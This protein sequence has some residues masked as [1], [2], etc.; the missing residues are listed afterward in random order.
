[1]APA[2]AEDIRGLFGPRARVLPAERVGELVPRG[3]E[4]WTTLVALLVLAYALEAAAG[5]IASVRNERRRRQAGG[6]DD[7]AGNGAGSDIDNDASSSNAGRLR[8]AG[9]AKTDNPDRPAAAGRRSERQEG[10]A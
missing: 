9:P 6:G 4:F 8:P 10:S 3:G 1:M 7:G 5:W 2:E